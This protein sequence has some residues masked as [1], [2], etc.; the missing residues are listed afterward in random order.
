MKWI[1]LAF[2]LACPVAWY[3]M[4]SWLSKFAYRIDLSWW[5]FVL[6]G[7]F[8]AFIALL[9]VGWQSIKAAMVNPVYSLKN[10]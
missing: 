9:I 10:E 3:A 8:T 5:I 1:L 7:A 2:V 4:T 6:A